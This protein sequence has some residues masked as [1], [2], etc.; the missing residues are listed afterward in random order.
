M[1]KANEGLFEKTFLV[2]FLSMSI[3]VFFYN[4][5]L[6][7]AQVYDGSQEVWFLRQIG[8]SRALGIGLVYFVVT[9]E[10]KK[11]SATVM[12]LLVVLA[13]FMVM[14]NQRGP[15]VFAVLTVA[16][17]LVAKYRRDVLRLFWICWGG[18]L[19]ILAV[20]FMAFLSQSFESFLTHGHKMK[21]ADAAKNR[22]GVYEPTAKIITSD[23]QSVIIGVGL[24]NWGKE[25]VKRF[26]GK[27]DD[28]A[29]KMRTEKRFYI[30]PHN[31]F[32]EILSELGLI[33]L[34]LFIFLFYPFKRLFN[35]SEKYNMLVLLGLL[36][37]LVSHDLPQNPALM[38]FN[39]LSIVSFKSVSSILE[40]SPQCIKDKK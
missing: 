17:Y 12:P 13:S 37:A 35:L 8:L 5:I 20:V 40:S 30:Y 21:L 33:G 22:F 36:Y 16:F 1:Y 3:L 23:L 32:L 38:I 34:T 4:I 31:I 10:W 18:V 7:Y 25:Y 15:V 2:T 9:A 29:V 6:G 24:G 28:L 11:R 27:Q 26:V 39:V 14:L 19:I